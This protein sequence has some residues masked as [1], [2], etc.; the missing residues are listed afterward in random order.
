MPL[1]RVSVFFN[2]M[3]RKHFLGSMWLYQIYRGCHPVSRSPFSKYLP[4]AKK[5]KKLHSQDTFFLRVSVN[6]LPTS[7]EGNKACPSPTPSMQCC[8]AVRAAR[9]KQQTPQLWMR[10]ETGGVWIVLFSKGT[11]FKD[12]VNN[13]VADY[14][15]KFLKANVGKY[16]ESQ[17]SSKNSIFG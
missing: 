16:R 10:G 6:F 13:F 17:I 15:M 1:P 3:P 4:T 12:S 9:R 14:R 11:P 8:A 7:K 2:A 5:K